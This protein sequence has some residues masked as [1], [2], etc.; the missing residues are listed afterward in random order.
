MLIL[1]GAAYNPKPA[2]ADACPESLK[3]THHLNFSATC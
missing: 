2:D 3:K 1:S